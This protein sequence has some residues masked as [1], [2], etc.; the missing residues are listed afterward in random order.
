MNVNLRAKNWQDW[1]V[2]AMTDLFEV[3][4]WVGNNLETVLQHLG[5]GSGQTRTILI[6]VINN[7]A[8]R[9]LNS[10]NKA[11][12]FLCRSP[13]LGTAHLYQIS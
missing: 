6:I 2:M 5:H 11:L 1:S 3:M 7:I 4:S 9:I 12:F 13:G 10:T 8:A